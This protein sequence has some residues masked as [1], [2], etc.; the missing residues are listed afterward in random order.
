MKI[1]LS[2][3]LAA[4]AAVSG[5]AHAAQYSSDADR[6]SQNRDEAL[7]KWRAANGQP[8]DRQPTQPATL[9]ERGREGAQSA[10]GFTQRQAE[11]VRNFGERQDRRLNNRFGKRANV[12][13]NPEGGGGK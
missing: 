6:R 10:K 11:K 9:R 12:N 3:V 5:V 2:L 1:L 13:A 8:A 4:T 7:T